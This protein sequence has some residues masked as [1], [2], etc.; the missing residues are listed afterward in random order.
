MSP[1][2]ITHGILLTT[3]QAAQYLALSSK[4]LERFRLDGTGPTFL[5]L[6]PGKRARVRYAKADLDAWLAANR[7]TST[8]AYGQ[9]VL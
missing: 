2:S 5:K 3:V 6:G 8:A 7:F 9:E 4:T 1:L